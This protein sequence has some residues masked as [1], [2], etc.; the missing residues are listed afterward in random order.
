M[1]ILVKILHK[2]DEERTEYYIN[3][4]LENRNENQEI[5]SIEKSNNDSNSSSND[6]EM[7][8]E[9]SQNQETFDL[10]NQDNDPNKLMEKLNKID[11][12]KVSKIV[13][14]G[15]GSCLYRAILISLGENESKYMELRNNLA[16]LIEISEI[17][18]DLI[19]ERNCKNKHELA[20]KIR[21]RNYYAD[22]LE[23]YLLSKLLNIII[24][25]YNERRGK[26]VIIKHDETKNPIGIVF[27]NFK[28]TDYELTNHYDA[29]LLNGRTGTGQ[30]I[31]LHNAYQYS[32]NYQEDTLDT[33]IWN[34]RSLNDMTK[35]MYLADI[36][37]NNSPD[38]VILLE[39]F[40]LDDFN[41]FIRNYKTYK[42]RNIIKRK[43]IA[44]LIHKNIL[45]SITQIAN[46]VEGRYIKLSLYSGVGKIYTI[47]G[48]YLEPNGNKGTIPE[49]IFESDVVVGDLNNCDSGLSKYKIY[50]YKN[51]KITSEIDVNNK[52]S[53]HSILKGEMNITLKRTEVFSNIEI[54][55][56][57]IIELNNITLQEALNKQNMK[58]L[59]N[60]HK[61][62]KINNYKN[63]PKDLD[64]YN[65]W[66]KIKEYNIQQYNTKYD[67]INKMIMSGSI[68]K[69]TWAK[70]NKMFINYK[71]KELYNGEHMKNEIICF[72]EEL[73]QSNKTRRELNREDFFGKI[74]SIIQILLN[75]NYTNEKP[76]WTP[77]SDSLDHN[78]FL[79]KK[80][81]KIIRG[82]NL[83]EEI[84]KFKDL[85]SIIYNIEGNADI[86]IH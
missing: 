20:E 32:K 54:N 71:N 2:I 45:A 24:A 39:T 41:L 70:L 76:I 27:L 36:I 73:Y 72:Y 65:E 84:V 35:R 78:G 52:I 33:L 68:D 6:I 67:K 44:I 48:I 42:T 81:E 7:K 25:I 30:K 11:I 9:T 66:D 28:E 55:D 61:T 15:D 31:S 50:H 86:F 77:K 47:S 10:K 38:I 59:L 51:I 49:E 37:S 79:Q 8:D 46:D 85:L 1:Q 63:N 69:S 3:Y 34:V 43:G 56:R 74:A 62:I 21:N 40:L 83:H 64:R 75:Q 60:P 14:R 5:K 18:I 58:K 16:N 4:A 26:W 82:D 57:K 22:H 19:E 29:L 12:D 53:D 13:V 23:I 80:L 17:D